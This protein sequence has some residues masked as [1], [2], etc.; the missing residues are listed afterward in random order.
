MKKVYILLLLALIMP[1]S[2]QTKKDKS[3]DKEY[4]K[5]TKWE[6]PDPRLR[7]DQVHYLGSHNAFLNKHA[8]WIYAQQKLSVKDQLKYG[9]RVLEVD[10]GQDGKHLSICHGSC[11]GTHKV[12]KKGKFKSFKDGV[13]NIAE[14]L[15]NHPNEIVILPLDNK[16]DTAIPA[17]QVDNEIASMPHVV[18]MVLTPNDWKPEEHDGEW[19]TLQWMR[20]HKKQIIIFNAAKGTSP[21]YTYYQWRYVA[22]TVPGTTDPEATA[23]LRNQSLEEQ[24]SSPEERAKIQRI[25]QMNHDTA[26]SEQYAVDLFNVGAKV[27]LTGSKQKTKKIQ[28]KSKISDNKR[29]T[30]QK[31][32][33]A[34]KR[35][36][37][38]GGKNPNILLL[39][40]TEKYIADNGLEQINQWNREEAAKLAK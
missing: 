31:C 17:D 28:E 26:I 13:Q 20:D 1:I 16:R 22:G 9:V 5:N 7:I 3:N 6:L 27:G 10:I 14:W 30:I 18:P 37:V 36:N 35:N 19:P 12:L 33:D 25:F 40:W 24:Y 38:G 4:E 21:K 8:G 32:I 2:V 29:S 34:C 39:D 11:H 23:R 15:K